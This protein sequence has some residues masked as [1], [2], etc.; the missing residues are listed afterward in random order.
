MIYFVCLQTTQGRAITVIFSLSFFFCFSTL[1]SPSLSFII[2]VS[3]AVYG[4]RVRWSE[5]TYV[6]L[7]V[8]ERSVQNVRTILVTAIK[9]YITGKNSFSSFLPI[10]KGAKITNVL[11]SRFN[12]LALLTTLILG[13]FCYQFSKIRLLYF[14]FLRSLTNVLKQSIYKFNLFYTK[15]YTKFINFPYLTSEI[16][17]FYSL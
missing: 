2:S 9:N 1:F 15:C 10:I 17:V 8:P 12:M 6:F 16:K 3:S 11:H 13:R 5:I 4:Q 14:F 7:I